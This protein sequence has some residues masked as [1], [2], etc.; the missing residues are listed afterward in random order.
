[1]CGGGGLYGVISVENM[2]LIWSSV[3]YEMKNI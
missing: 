2:T 1:V 3:D